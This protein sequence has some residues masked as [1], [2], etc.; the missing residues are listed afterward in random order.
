MPWYIALSGSIVII[1]L[2]IYKKLNIGL[3]MLVGAIT[4][5]LLDGLGLSEF[6]I[7]FLSGLWNSITIMLV[8]SI[9][10]LGVLGYILKETGALNEI[11]NNLQS[12]LSDIRLIAV[13]MPALIGMLTVPG[14]AILSAPLCVETG[15]QL[16]MPSER[17][18]V[19]NIWFRHVFYFI[20]PLFP[21]L[22]LA[23]QLS[24][25]NISRY[26]LH[27]LPLTIAGVLFGFYFLFRNYS[28]GTT[29]IS[30]S[31]QKLLQL[32]KSVM[33]LILVMILVVFFNVYFPLANYLPPKD[34]AQEFARRIKTLIL[35]GIKI[36]VAFVIIGIMVYKEM[37]EHTEV[38][39]DLTNIVIDLGVP[40][41]FLLTF[42]PFL[43]GML[44]GDNSASVAIL[45]PMFLPIIP[46]GTA[47]S[48]AYFAYL[49]ASS[50]SG[51]IISPAHPCFSLTK[52]YC[53]GDTKK[54][55]LLTLPLLGVVMLVGFLITLLFGYY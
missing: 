20:I 35:P 38:I 48:S 54:I 1:I 32:L 7:V 33:P 29:G 12:L 26:V 27:N 41:I 11:I 3:T 40:L 15:N 45:F 49:Y 16:N 37:L 51:H 28:T 19:I 55:I 8:I 14:G 10:L 17:Q 42:I 46:A 24:A 39:I 43:V 2:G 23:S 22:I 13:A 50:T 6:F 5:G 31:W 9:I 53:K 52:E 21:S 30:I 4:L 47:A 36:P 18:A 44:T 25:I 34:R